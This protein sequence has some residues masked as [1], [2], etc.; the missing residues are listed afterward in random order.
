MF[1]QAF[2]WGLGATLGGAIGLMVFV[3]MYSG[4][5]WLTNIEAVKRDVTTTELTLS[6]LS[7]RN[8]L[9]QQQIDTLDE[10]SDS[11]RVMAERIARENEELKK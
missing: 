2:V 7:E 9:T 10:I 3:V 6:L 8:N 4:W 1:W 5:K 11:V